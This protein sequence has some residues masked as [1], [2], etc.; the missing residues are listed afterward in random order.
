[1]AVECGVSG[2]VVSNHGA[3]QLDTVPA[4][5]DALPDVVQAVAGRCEVYLDGGIRLGTDVLKAL[6]LG[7]KAVFIGRLAIYGLA[8]NGRSGVAQVLEI[9]KDELSTAMALSG[10]RCI[11]D[12]NKELLRHQSYYDAKL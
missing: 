2:I 5:L 4:T 3:R 6:A 10:C 1:M 11:A 8:Y 12:I 7:A 9:L